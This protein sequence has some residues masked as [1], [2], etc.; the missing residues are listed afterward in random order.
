M[1]W[2]PTS[3]KLYCDDR[4]LNSQ[5]LAVTLNDPTRPDMA[6]APANP[7]HQPAYILLDQALGGVRGGD[8]SHTPFP[9]RFEVDYVRVYQKPAP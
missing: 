3:I 9:I 7:F 8:P 4:L 1:D 6:H 5:D 2:D